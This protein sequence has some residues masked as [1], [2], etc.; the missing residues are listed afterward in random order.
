MS[1]NPKNLK[2]PFKMEYINLFLLQKLS[3]LFLNLQ[4][5]FILFK[6]KYF[7]KTYKVWTQ[8]N[9]HQGDSAP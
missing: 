4:G 9:Q 6:T 7:R 3:V 8:G 2:R 5:M 1:S